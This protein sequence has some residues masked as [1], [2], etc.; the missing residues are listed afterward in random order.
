[1]L[2]RFSR[3]QTHSVLQLPLIAQRLLSVIWSTSGEKPDVI[4]LGF[5]LEAF[6]FG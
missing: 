5:E 6:V 3:L 2:Q 1:M 4:Q